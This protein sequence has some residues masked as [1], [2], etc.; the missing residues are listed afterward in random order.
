MKLGQILLI[1]TGRKCYWVV[2]TAI[3]TMFG[4]FDFASKISQNFL[5]ISVQTDSSLPSTELGVQMIWPIE[6]FRAA[7]GQPDLSLV[8]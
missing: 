5:Q 2:E 4:K 3:L 8:D 1:H 6:S 7:A